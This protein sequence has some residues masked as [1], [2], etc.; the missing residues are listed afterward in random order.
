M[1]P[2][3]W[4]LQKGFVTV[5]R[6][7][8]CPGLSPLLENQHAD[9]CHL[10]IIE[11]LF[12]NVIKGQLVDLGV[13]SHVK[14][15]HVPR[16]A[17]VTWTGWVRMGIDICFIW[18]VV[19]FPSPR[20]K[21]RLRGDLKEEKGSS[22]AELAEA[23]APDSATFV[24]FIPVFSYLKLITSRTRL[25]SWHSIYF[26]L[27]HWAAHPPWKASGSVGA[28]R[29]TTMGCWPQVLSIFP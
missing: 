23:A 18:D 3:A 16:R 4:V 25:P 1:I 5:G 27:I 22:C 13:S 2:K 28:L 10:Q 8:S 11:G 21:W 20:W 19:L 9:I 6:L 12:F 14:L 17:L 15:I 7:F 26:L 24:V 29:C